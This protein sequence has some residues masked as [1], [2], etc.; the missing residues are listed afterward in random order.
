MYKKYIELSYSFINTEIGLN[1][2][3]IEMERNV[4]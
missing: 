3:H 1:F 4:R 2:V